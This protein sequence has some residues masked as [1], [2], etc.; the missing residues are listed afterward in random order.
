MSVLIQPA[1]ID[2]VAGIASIVEAHADRGQV[3]PRS[4]GDIRDSIGDWVVAV[5]GE[6]VLACGSLVSYSSML[7]EVRSLVV[8]DQVK[9]MGLGMAVL[10]ALIVNARQRGVGTLFALTRV[11][12]FF[13]RA[14]FHITVR[15]NFPEKIWRDCRL[16]LIK[17]RCDEVAVILPLD[18]QVDEIVSN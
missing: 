15:A 11:V 10:D 9:R 5:D 4:V 3:L 17:D 12:P 14:G 8:A 1:T 16:C 7:S 13:E 6:S 2:T 18:G